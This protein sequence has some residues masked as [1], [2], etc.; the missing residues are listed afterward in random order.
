ML[1]RSHIGVNL[2]T[3]CDSK[4]VIIAARELKFLKYKQEIP[5][6]NQVLTVLSLTLCVIFGCK[7]DSNT[8]PD[9]QLVNNKD[10]LTFGA[11]FKCALLVV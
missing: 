11:N 4:A 2:V 10:N 1:F 9:K 8:Y 7:M 3:K 5:T 6:F